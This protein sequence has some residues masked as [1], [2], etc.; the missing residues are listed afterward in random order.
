M[1]AIRHLLPPLIL[2]CAVPNLADAALS[3]APPPLKPVEVS[4]Y[5]GRWY[6]FARLHNRIEENCTSAQAQYSREAD[7]RIA[8]VETCNTSGGGEKV[9]HAGVRVLDP[10]TNAKLRLS[11]FPFI[12]KDYWVLDHASDYAWAIVGTNDGK[13]LWLFAREPDPP[14]AEKAAIVARAKAM[15]YDTSKLIYSQWRRPASA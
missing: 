9:Y 3:A 15:G 2:A 1:R 5:L 10:G 12:S 8:A 13:Y 14:A 11:V 6:E 7:G 4:R